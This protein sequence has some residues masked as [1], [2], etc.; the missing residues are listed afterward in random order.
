MHSNTS[1]PLWKM[2]KG[3]TCLNEELSDKG[4]FIKTHLEPVG[5]YA[6]ISHVAK[7]VSVE[8]FPCKDPFI[9]DNQSKQS[10]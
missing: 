1:L 7:G 8:P 2:L 10:V 6:L 4:T 9:S 3:T 5:L